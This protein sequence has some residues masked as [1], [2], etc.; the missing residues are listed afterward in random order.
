MVLLLEFC[1][2]FVTNEGAIQVWWWRLVWSL[3]RFAGEIIIVGGL[4]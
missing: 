2:V 1:S 3:N 4:G